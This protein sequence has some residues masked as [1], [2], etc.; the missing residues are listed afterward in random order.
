MSG[1]SEQRPIVVLVPGL[2]MPAW[3]MLP[4][5]WR[6]RRRGHR[7]VGFGYPSARAAL[8]ENASRLAR[9]IAR[10]DAEQVHLVGH[11]LGG[12]L[13]LHTAVRHRPAQVRRIVM[14]GS[15]YDDSYTARRLGRREWGRRILGHTVRQWLDCERPSAPPGLEVGVIAGTLACGLG[16]VVAPDSERPHDGVIRSSETRV[17]GMAAYVEVRAS[18]ASMLLSPT[19]A[20][21]IDCFL[22]CGQFDRVQSAATPLAAKLPEL[23]RERR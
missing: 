23:D 10:L 8:D 13:A 2:W 16:L 4:L 22:V 14:A 12:V 9:F 20:R 17:P 1:E 5:A 19:V 21:L 3:V 15:P 18:H 6:L 11:S 7:C